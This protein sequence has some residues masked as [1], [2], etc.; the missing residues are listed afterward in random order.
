MTDVANMIDIS[1][2]RADVS[3][4][5][6]REL[7]E[8]A[9]KYRCACAFVMP[10]YVPD[11]RA[12]LDGEPAIGVGSVVGFPSGADTTMAKAYQ[13]RQLAAEGCCELDMVINVGMLISERYSEV[14]ND[15]RAVIDSSEG[16]PV[17]VIL[18]VAY[19]TD[20]QI[21]KGCDICIDAGASFVKTGTGWARKGTTVDHIKLIKSHVGDRIKIKASGGIR[22]LDTIIKMNRSGATRFGIGVRSVTSIMQECRSIDSGAA[23]LD[24][25]AVW[26]RGGCDRRAVR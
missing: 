5:E 22:S 19:L 25:N 3:D 26:E 17:K 1:A 8:K 15:I 24:G 6:I 2:V 12:Y 10:C 23:D 7:A 9:R 14:K 20:D 13:A 16:L 11:V 18:E 4:T 21:R